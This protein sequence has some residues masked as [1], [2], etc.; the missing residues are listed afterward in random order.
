M[1]RPTP[2]PR[3]PVTAWTL[4]VLHLCYRGEKIEDVLER[5]IRMLATADGKVDT[6]GRIKNGRHL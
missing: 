3:Q 2:P 1:T 6:G 5:A 4:Q